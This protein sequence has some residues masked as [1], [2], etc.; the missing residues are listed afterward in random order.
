MRTDIEEALGKIPA[1]KLLTQLIQNSLAKSALVDRILN[2]TVSDEVKVSLIGSA[3]SS[4]AIEHTATLVADL[5]SVDGG[6]PIQT[7][8]NLI[9]WQSVESVLRD[10]VEPREH[11]RERGQ[12]SV[13]ESHV[14]FIE[15]EASG[16]IK[17]GRS[18]DPTS[19]FNAIRTMSPD[20]LVFL[21]SV[22]EKVYSEA[23]LHKKFAEH[24]KHGEWFDA[25]PEIRELIAEVLT[26]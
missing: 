13:A 14:Y 5:E 23:D 11:G 8:L 1:E 17:I 22:P 3:A 10:V 2:L 4:S 6:S 26:A 16:L 21:G 15:S 24:R 25:A 19:R 9:N 12:D 20:A 18:I 7:V